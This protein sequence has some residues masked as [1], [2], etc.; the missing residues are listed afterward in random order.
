MKLQ[1]KKN[2]TLIVLALALFFAFSVLTVSCA[3]MSKET[4]SVKGGDAISYR[5]ENGEVITAQ[6]Y[7]LSDDSLFFVKLTMPDSKEY[8]LPLSVSAS[9]A[10]YTDGREFVWWTKG[11]TA[12][13]ETRDEEGNWEIKYKDC[14]EL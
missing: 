10:R 13:V 4:L 1:M 7:S 8:T 6:Y 2:A 12:F 5:C 11:D 3:S 9:G 14:K